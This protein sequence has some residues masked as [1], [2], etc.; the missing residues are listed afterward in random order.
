MSPEL[1]K[2]I[3]LLQ[4]QLGYSEQAGGYTK[5][6]D[7]Y[8]KNVEFDSDYS[9]QPWCDMF[10]SWAAHR[11]GYEKWFGQFAYTPAHAEWFADQGAWGTTPKPGAVV[12]FDW[13]GSHVIDNI[14]H[15]GIVT[16][17]DGD[18][19]HTIEGN[20]DGQYAKAKVRDQTYVAGYGYPDKV[21]AQQDARVLAGKPS[22]VAT[23]ALKNTAAEFPMPAAMV[24][25]PGAAGGAGQPAAGAGALVLPVLIAVLA[26]IVCL[27]TRRAAVRLAASARRPAS[28]SP[29]PSAADPRE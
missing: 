18:T 8:G 21:K 5:Y 3:D 29:S 15:V 27:K 10:L 11:L 28:P 1:Q 19:I 12:F 9:A 22:S 6:G 17:V 24:G 14:D 4:T 23:P 25:V 2:L 20:I 16:S 13:G 7:W 26:L